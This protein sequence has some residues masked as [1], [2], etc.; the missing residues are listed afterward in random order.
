MTRENLTHF[1]FYF[2]MTFS[3]GL[4]VPVVLVA[5]VIF[6]VGIVKEVIYDQANGGV[7]DLYN[8]LANP[9]GILTGWLLLT[10]I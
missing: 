6:L 7:S 9:L 3:L 2:L 1:L 5:T 8:I 10:V 4:L